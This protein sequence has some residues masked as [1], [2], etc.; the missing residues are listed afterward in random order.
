MTP[1]QDWTDFGLTNPPTGNG[2]SALQRWQADALFVLWKIVKVVREDVASM[3]VNGCD[4]HSDMLKT[5]CTLRTQSRT[6]GKIERA[7]MQLGGIWKW[8]LA[9]LGTIA[10]LLT[11]VVEWKELTG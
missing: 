11:I 6:F 10:L 2:E 3:R 1:E 4:H 9:I 8:V 5:L 7:W